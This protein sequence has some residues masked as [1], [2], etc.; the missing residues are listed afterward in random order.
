MAPKYNIYPFITYNSVDFGKNVN[1][2]GSPNLCGST[3]P[4]VNIDK[5]KKKK[6]RILWKE[7]EI[8]AAIDVKI[9]TFLLEINA[10]SVN[11]LKEN[12]KKNILK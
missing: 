9:L 5:K 6:S 4:K 12:Q 10:I 2:I 1:Q 3:F 8:G 11:F 7:K